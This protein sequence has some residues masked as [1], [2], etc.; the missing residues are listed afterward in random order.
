MNKKAQNSNKQFLYGTAALAF[1]VIAIV[2]MFI[3]MTSNLS[4]NQ[5]NNEAYQDVYLIEFTK[6]FTG[7]STTIYINDSLLWD[8]VIPTD[9]F[10]LHV[11]RFAEQSML[12]VGDKKYNTTA[13]F[14][15]DRKGARLILNKQNG[16]VSI[17]S[18]PWE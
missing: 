2:F 3:Y 6:A 1:G 13:S 16:F 8:N 10:K 14:N 15:L 5:A 18:I 9:T 12:M 7:D 11:N 17:T 4:K